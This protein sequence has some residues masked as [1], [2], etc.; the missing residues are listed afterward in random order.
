MCLELR[1]N[2]LC[3]TLRAIA[4]WEDYLNFCD[5]FCFAIPR[6]DTELWEAIENKTGS[7]I[8]ILAIDF[9]SELNES[10]LKSKFAL[11]NL[12]PALV[13]Q[14]HLLPSF[15]NFTLRIYHHRRLE[16]TAF[17]K[18]S[19]S[20]PELDTFSSW[21]DWGRHKAWAVEQCDRQPEHQIQNRDRL[22]LNP[23]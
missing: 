9:K 19:R 18:E 11:Y 3:L 7:E 17:P 12:Q 22:R 5:Y 14:V 13:F 16:P 10:L 4:L 20:S 21:E 1:L 2:L 15:G 6:E 8:G 23:S